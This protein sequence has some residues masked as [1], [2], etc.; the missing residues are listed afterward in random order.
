MIRTPTRWKVWAWDV[1]HQLGHRDV[2][3]PDECSKSMNHFLKV[4]W[5]DLGGYANCNAR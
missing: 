4:V 3:I 5:R 2:G 1:L